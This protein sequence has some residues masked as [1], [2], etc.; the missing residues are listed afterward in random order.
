MDMETQDSAEPTTYRVVVVEVNDVAESRRS[1]R[2]N[3]YVGVTTQSRSVRYEQ[4][5]RGLGPS[6]IRGHIVRLRPDLYRSYRP[7]AAEDSARLKAQGS[8]LKAQGSSGKISQ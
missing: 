6:W 1:N 7:V 4:L 2:P 8:R 5:L 3:V